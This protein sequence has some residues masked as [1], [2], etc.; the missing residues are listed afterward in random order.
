MEPDESVRRRFNLNGHTSAFWPPTQKLEALSK[1]PSFP[2]EGKEL[3]VVRVY[4]IK[5]FHVI[6]KYVAFVDPREA[7]SVLKK[8]NYPDCARIILLRS[9]IASDLPSLSERLLLG[10]RF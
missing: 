4:V 3:N 9:L 2:L 1:T 6:S 8:T 10:W 5:N 7:I